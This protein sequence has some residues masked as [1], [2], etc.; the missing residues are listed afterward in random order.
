MRRSSTISVR[1]EETSFAH[2]YISI[3]NKLLNNAQVD[4]EIKYKRVEKESKWFLIYSLIYKK[5]RE[6]NVPI[7][8]YKYLVAKARIR[9]KLLR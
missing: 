6:Y 7:A 2:V 4:K 3:L 5:D 9:C 8:V 1:Y